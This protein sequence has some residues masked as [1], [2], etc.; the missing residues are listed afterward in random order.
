MGEGISVQRIAPCGYADHTENG[1]VPCPKSG[2]R[3]RVEDPLGYVV[4]IYRCREHSD[5]VE[6]EDHA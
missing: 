1:A 3:L 4:V 6:V 5:W 2:K